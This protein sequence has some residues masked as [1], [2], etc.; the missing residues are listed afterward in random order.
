MLGAA[1]KAILSDVEEVSVKINFE[2]FYMNVKEI[3]PNSD[4]FSRYGVREVAN[5]VSV[6]FGISQ[7]S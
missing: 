4:I 6:R 3:M 5:I 7:V 1:V 2:K